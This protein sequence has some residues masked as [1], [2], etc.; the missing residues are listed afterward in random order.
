[1]NGNPIEIG[2]NCWIGRG[3]IILAG[4]TIGD[5][6]I[7]AANSVVNKNIPSNTIYGGVPAKFIKDR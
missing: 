3:C 7:I 6:A 2:E 5:G 4:V 1:M